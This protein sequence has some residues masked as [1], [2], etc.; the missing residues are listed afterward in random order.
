[1]SIASKTPTT[2]RALT[3]KPFTLCVQWPRLGPYHIA[4]LRATHE[5]ARKRN[6]SVIALETAHSDATYAWNIESAQTP[7]HREVIFKD[8]V[9]EKLDAAVIHKAV[10]ARLDHIQ[11]DAIAIISYSTPDARAC[12][13]WCKKNRKAAILMSASKEDDAPRI[14][15]RE[16]IKAAL[17]RLYDAAL[18]GGTPQQSYLEK[19]GFPASHIYQ[20][21]NTVDNDFFSTSAESYRSRVDRPLDLPGLDDASPYFLAINRFLSIKNLDRLIEAYRAYRQRT[22]TP[23][24][25]LLV[26][27]GPTRQ[28]LEAQVEQNSID[29]VKFCGFQQIQ[30]LPAYYAYAGAFVHPTLKDTWGLVVNEAM[31]AGLPVIVSNRA[32]CA[33]DLV[34]HG[35]NG[36]IFEPE[37]VKGLTHLLSTMSAPKTNRAA[38]SAASEQ[39]IAHW[40]PENFAEHLWKA[41]DS[42][43]SRKS[44]ALFG[45]RFLLS[46]IQRLSRNVNSFHSVKD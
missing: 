6:C 30:H 33:Q 21:C 27:D 41:V 7:F 1:M 15:W 20:G 9:Y 13:L 26:G 35:T 34:K 17:I 46:S 19:L 11:P 3:T 12:L 37:N 42:A 22:K 44:R 39:I 25:L 43:H 2:S 16:R 10:T 8:G 18:V 14:G 4:R 28:D 31:A 40:S 24:R 29:G 32:G 23:W 38:M 36:F 5:A 45:E